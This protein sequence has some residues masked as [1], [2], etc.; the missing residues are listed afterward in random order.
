MLG[1]GFPA[2]PRVQAVEPGQF[3]G[4]EDLHL[5]RVDGV[6]I[7]GQRRASRH[8]VAGFQHAAAAVLAGEPAQVEPLA[9]LVEQFAGAVMRA[10]MRV[11]SSGSSRSRVP[12]R[13]ACV[14]ARA[15]GM[16]ASPKRC[17]SSD[18]NCRCRWVKC[19]GTAMAKTRSTG[20]PSL[21]ARNPPPA[22]TAGRPR[23]CRSNAS[24]RP[25]G[26]ATP[27][28][29]AVLPMRSRWRRLSPTAAIGPGASASNRAAASMTASRSDRARP[30][31]RCD[32]R[33]GTRTGTAWCRNRAGAVRRN[34]R[35]APGFRRGGGR[36]FFPCA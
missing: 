24:L 31:P 26:I 11:A 20:S 10:V 5:V 4:S 1:D 17:A 36:P 25:C 33:S 15:A 3:L 13:E 21:G 35:C 9:L 12:H 8:G 27:W 32:P 34:R 16:S 14:A 28:P 2:Q 18:S 6:E 22:A 30:A 29:I 7:A 19:S 23:A